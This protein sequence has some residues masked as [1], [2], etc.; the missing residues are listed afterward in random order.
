MPE[1]ERIK[2]CTFDSK[3]DALKEKKSFIP[4]SIEDVIEKPNA[5][6]IRVDLL[7]DKTLTAMV[8]FSFLSPTFIIC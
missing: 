3:N 1:G 5:K 8:I 2:T 7:K 6:I 4:L